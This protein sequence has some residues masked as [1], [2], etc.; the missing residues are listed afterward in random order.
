MPARK[1][2]G[3]WVDDGTGRIGRTAAYDS[4]SGELI[5][6]GLQNHSA[7]LRAAGHVEKSAKDVSGLVLRKGDGKIYF[8]D[9]SGFF[10]RKLT[11]VERQAIANALE[12][13]FGIPAI[14]GKAPIN[15]PGAP[16]T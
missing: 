9:H 15:R 10:P 4:N 1:V 6:G 16:G 7:V 12:A 8:D 2:V 11:E 5:I 14:Y 3:D 13:E